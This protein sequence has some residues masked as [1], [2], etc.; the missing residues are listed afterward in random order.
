MK[1]VPRFRVCCTTRLTASLLRDVLSDAGA[2]QP[3]L[4]STTVGNMPHA[5][6]TEACVS[7]GRQVLLTGSYGCDSPRKIP[8]D[9]EQ[10]SQALGIISN[11]SSIFERRLQHAPPKTIVLGSGFGPEVRAQK[12]AHRHDSYC[13]SHTYTFPGIVHVHLLRIC[14][15]Q[16]SLRSRQQSLGVVLT[17]RISCWVQ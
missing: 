15:Q 7:C 5:F 17:L 16:E 14:G 1:S 10:A 6:C 12:A 13:T 2:L 4:C 11:E 3:T 8:R 9:F